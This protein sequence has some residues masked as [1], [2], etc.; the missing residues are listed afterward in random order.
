MAALLLQTEMDA[1]TAKNAAE[2]EMTKKVAEMEMAKKVAE[3]E[4]AKKVA[5][6]EKVK[7]VAKMEMAKAKWV[8]KMAKQDT[9]MVKTNLV[10]LY[11]RQAVETLVSSFVQA[12][13]LRKRS[14]YSI[15]F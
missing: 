1:E 15:L 9:E 14:G 11:N 8:A 3:V 7:R 4:M 10:S 12:S 5:E 13:S 2:M 6:M